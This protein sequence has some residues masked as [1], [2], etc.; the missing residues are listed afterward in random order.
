MTTKNDF[1][2]ISYKINNYENISGKS[3]W[4]DIFLQASESSI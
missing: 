4:S 2:T 3:Y 1:V